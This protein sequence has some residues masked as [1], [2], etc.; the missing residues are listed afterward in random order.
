M[1]ESVFSKGLRIE[2]DLIDVLIKTIKIIMPYKSINAEMLEITI[3]FLAKIDIYNLFLL[4]FL[5]VLT[6]GFY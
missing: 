6:I 2:L 4:G 1:A 5:D 3:F